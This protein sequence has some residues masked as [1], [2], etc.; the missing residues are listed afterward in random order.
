MP[1][2]TYKIAAYGVLYCVVEG[3]TSRLKI[4]A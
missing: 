4:Y 3:Y 2:F 1:E